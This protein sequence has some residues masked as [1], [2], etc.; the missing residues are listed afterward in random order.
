MNMPTSDLSWS[1]SRDLDLRVRARIGLMREQEVVRRIW[2]AD[3]SVWSGTSEDR[4]LGWLSLPIDQ[5]AFADRA[6]RLAH[7]IKHEQ[8]ADMVLLGMGGSSLAP[9]VIRS[10]IGVQAGYP[11]LH[12]LDSTDPAQ[13][14]AVERRIDLRRTIFLVASKSGSTLEV[15]IL[16]QYFFSRAAQKL[17]EREAGRHFVLT[18]DPGSKLHHASE[19]ERFREVFAGVPSVGG[20]YSALSNF[21]LVP[22]AL[23]GADLSLMLDHAEGMARRCA[24]DE[25]DNAAFL[26]GAM[27]GELALAG[28]DKPTLVAPPALA[29]FGAWLEQLVAESLGKQGKG[30]IPIDGEA[31]GGPEVYGDDRVFVQLRSTKSPDA[32]ADRAIGALERSGHPIVRIDWS[33][34]YALGAEFYRWEFATAVMG[35]VLGVNPFDQPDVEESKIVTR[36]LAA[37]Y[38]KSG[39]LPDDPAVI[40]DLGLSLYADPRTRKLLGNHES[41]VEYIDAFLHLLGPGDYF[42]VLAFIE[43]TDAHRA[44][45]EAIRALVR[46]R[47]KVA[48]TVGFGPRFLHS[49]GQAHK[50]GPNTGVFLQITCEHTEEV[51]VPEEHYSF[52][53][54][55]LAQARGD[56]E[57]LASRGRRLLRVHFKEVE[58]GLRALQALVQQSLS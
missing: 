44:A 4:W 8:I 36:R 32:V 15:N 55:A 43:M 25:D 3:P 41:V 1:L 21:G 30:I 47:R 49:T 29:G 23:I 17:G 54:I 6:V 48:T 18:T 2:N 24:T 50:G 22:A 40:R 19:Q 11:N 27:L 5:R 12:V 52:G 53:T 10:I 35:A 16:K 14:L 56:F 31:V 45:L 42:G 57:V 7:Q 39:Q 20:R 33:D 28:R 37:E 9:E 46:D 38:E 13:I 34:R 26:L 58:S 51:H